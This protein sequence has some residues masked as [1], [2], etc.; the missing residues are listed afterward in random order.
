MLCAVCLL[1]RAQKLIS[2]AN[3]AITT[4]RGTALCEAHALK[5]LNMT[6][7]LHGLGIEPTGT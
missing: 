5:K 2:T 6:E 3:P 7:V 4:I 1:R